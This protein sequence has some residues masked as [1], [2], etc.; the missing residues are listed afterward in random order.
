MITKST[1]SPIIVGM[2]AVLVAVAAIGIVSATTT[3]VEKDV[4]ITARLL[5]SG[6]VE[7]GLQERTDGGDWSEILIPPRNKFPYSR[8]EVDRW[9]F[10]SPVALTPVELTAPAA[11]PTSGSLTMSGAG[12]TVRTITATEGRYIVSV[13]VAGNH[14]DGR[15]TNF[16]VRI[17]DAQGTPELI[18]NEITGDWG[19]DRA[20]TVGG[21]FGLE[22][23]TLTV[24]VVHAAPGA[25]WAITITPIT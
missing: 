3:Q 18:A 19:A 14:E 6:K 16:V 2:L 12:V 17:V 5:D 8:A 23:G 4:R 21:F 25:Q 22:P 9:L 7:F 13:E 15:A 10:S 11:D 24:E 1:T 20:I